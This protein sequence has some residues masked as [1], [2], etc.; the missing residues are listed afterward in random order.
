MRRLVERDGPGHERLKVVLVSGPPG[1]GKSATAVAAATA[2]REAFPD[3]Q[4][5]LD[6]RGS[7]GSPVDVADA[8]A[9]L[10]SGLGVRTES[11]Q[12]DLN[13]SRSL[14]RS[15]MARRRMLVLLDDA[16]DAEQVV[17]LLPGPGRSLVIVTS[18][19]WL[20][21]VEADVHLSLEPL[22]AEESLSMLGTVVGQDRVDREPG[23]SR[24]IVEAC[25][26]LPLAIR[27][28]GE[29]L[30]AR[31]RHP[32]RVLADRL[33]CED[34]LLDE[35]SLNGLSMRR[36]LE[37]SYRTLDPGKQKCF[38]VLGVLDAN[39]ITAAGLGELLRLPVHAADRELEGLVHE[40]LLSPGSTYQGIPTYWMPTVLHTYAR[41]RLTIEGPHLRLREAGDVHVAEPRCRAAALLTAG[42]VDTKGDDE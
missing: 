37:A 22:T 21:R 24:A 26:R 33:D 7:T 9:S 12:G 14:Y 39:N 3:G 32:L 31:P 18:R 35:L 17:P 15:L 25:G 41:E 36:L 30:A 10:L 13:R 5:Y 6:L 27:I 42:A 40:G 29:R 8:M 1:F 34:R 11:I 19:R 16:V 20:A 23:A 2:I 4:L 38:R 28:A